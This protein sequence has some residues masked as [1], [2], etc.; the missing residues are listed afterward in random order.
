MKKKVFTFFVVGALALAGCSTEPEPQPGP[1][2]GSVKPPQLDKQA[3]TQEEVNDAVE[4]VTYYDEEETTPIKPASAPE[5]EEVIK[6]KLAK[7]KEKVKEDPEDQKYRDFVSGLLASGE[8]LSDKERKA[9]LEYWKYLGS[10]ES[11]QANE[12]IKQILKKLKEGKGTKA[13]VEELKG[14]QPIK[15]GVELKDDKK[16]N[17]HQD[18]DDELVPEPKFS[19]DPAHR[20]DQIGPEPKFSGDPAHR[21]DQ[22]GPEPKFSGD[23]AHRGDQLVPEPKYSGNQPNDDDQP[24][25]N[26]EQDQPGNNEQ[27]NDNEQDQPGNNEQGN[28]NE[29]GQPGNNEQGND[30]E[31]GQPGNNEQGNDNEQGQPGNN[32]G[33]DRDKD[34]DED[35]DKDKNKEKNGYDRKAAKEYAYQWW[36]KRN[37]EEFGYYSRVWGGCY[38]CWYDCTNFIS[39]V[40]YKGGIK[41]RTSG[42]NLWFYSDNG[43]HN[44][45]GVANSFYNHFKN[46]AKL[47]Q[48]KS[49]LKIGDV[50][51]FDFDSNNRVDHTAVVTKLTEHGVFVTQHTYDKKDSNIISWFYTP[52]AKLYAFDMGS[53]DN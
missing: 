9:L 36:N 47:V 3:A 6:K 30:N 4:N 29:Q 39:Q 52:G 32:E 25:N 34:K 21:G 18:E 53:A 26:N 5:A 20:G 22:I 19:G 45:W 15:P 1:D 33:R 51:A 38:D 13:D 37:N 41:Q 11:K 43:P 24:G 17:K 23:P 50:I 10:I 40:V 35:K 49:D 42:S 46:R 16:P 14:L 44:A 8:N 2:S 12:K 31:Q 28:D 48:N 27:G 7:S